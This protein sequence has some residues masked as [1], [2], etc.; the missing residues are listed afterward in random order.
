MKNKLEKEDLSKLTMEDL[1]LLYKIQEKRAQ[2]IHSEWLQRKWLSNMFKKE[3]SN[4]ST[5]DPTEKEKERWLAQK[6]R[7]ERYKKWEDEYNKTH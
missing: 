6:L 7:A 3:F 1:E 5:N 2:K 4:T